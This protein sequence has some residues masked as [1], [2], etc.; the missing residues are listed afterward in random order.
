M[1]IAGINSEI[2]SFQYTAN[3]KARLLIPHALTDIAGPVAH[4]PTVGTFCRL[5]RR[6]PPGTVTSNAAVRLK[7]GHATGTTR[8]C[9]KATFV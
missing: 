4:V 9:C 3:R 8:K 5:L 7:L 1:I 6:T 2:L